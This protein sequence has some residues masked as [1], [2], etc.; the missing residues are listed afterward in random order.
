LVLAVLLA[1]MVLTQYFQ[2]SLQLAVVAVEHKQLLL[3][4]VALAVVVMAEMLQIILVQQA[5]LMKDLQVN[6]EFHLHQA[7]VEVLVK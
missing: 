1:L 3:A 2:L 7:A 5:L 6:Q 4:L